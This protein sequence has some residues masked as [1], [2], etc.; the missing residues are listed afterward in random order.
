MNENLLNRIK[1]TTNSYEIERKGSII[2]RLGIR[3]FDI[4]FSLV[5]IGLTAPLMIIIAFLI[6]SK[7]PEGSIFFKQ[8]RLGLNG[9]SFEVYKFRTM[10]PNAEEELQKLLNRDPKIKKEYET[11][12]KLKND[13]R[14]IPKIGVF[15][16]KTSLDELPQFFNVLFGTMSVVGP[17]PY[18][19]AEFHQYS[20]NTINKIVSVKPG[21]T[22]YWQTQPS[23]HDTTFDNRVQS[24][25]EYIKNKNIWLDIKIIFKTVWVMIARRGM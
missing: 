16:R 23:R 21:I 8:K 22:G 10:I 11:F 6:K 1:T 19:A 15:L 3:L 2:N 17:R 13:V 25:L 18:I 4:G 7:S 20:Q 12:R 14:I 5:A 24:D 9:K